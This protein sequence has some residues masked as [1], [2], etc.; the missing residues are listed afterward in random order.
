MADKT[1]DRPHRDGA[2][3]GYEYYA[4]SSPRRVREDQAL[5]PKRHRRLSKLRFLARDGYFDGDDIPPRQGTSWPRAATRRAGEGGPGYT[6]P[7]EF[8]PTCATTGPAYFDGERWHEKPGRSLYH[9]RGHPMAGRQTRRLR[10]GRRR[11]GRG[12]RDQ[13]AGPAARPRTGRQGR[14]GRDRR[15]SPFLSADLQYPPRGKQYSHRAI[16]TA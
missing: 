15:A 9:V 13:G 12:R 3:E 8:H 10:G 16:E 6:I 4:T 14:T 2:Q 1:Y 7:D 5:L 11:H